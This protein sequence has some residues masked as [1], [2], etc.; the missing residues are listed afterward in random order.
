MAGNRDAF[1][2]RTATA[3]SRSVKTLAWCESELMRS[4]FTFS[5][6]SIRFRSCS[7]GESRMITSFISLSIILCL[8]PSG[9]FAGMP[10]LAV[11][12]IS[13]A[14][15]ASSRPEPSSAFFPFSRAFCF[16]FS[17]CFSASY[18][19]HSS[20]V[21]CGSCGMFFLV[22][23]RSFSFIHHSRRLA[24]LDAV[25]S[26]KVIAGCPASSR[27]SFSLFHASF[28]RASLRA[29]FSSSV[30]GTASSATPSSSPSS[31]GA[32]RP[33][34]VSMSCL[35]F[36]AAFSSA[37]AACC[38][39][40]FSARISSG[41]FSAMPIAPIAATFSA[42][43]ALAT[44]AAAASFSAASLTRRASSFRLAVASSAASAP[45]T[46]ASDVRI[47]SSL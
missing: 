15:M 10:V 3:L 47:A 6:S 24:S 13:P 35:A 38:A 29:S 21:S 40:N 8:M 17:F 2:S 32:S 4:F 37:L 30:R 19:S 1:P 28:C 33:A 20:N 42:T 31:A 26:S 34:A 39:A 23:R 22:A 46:W 43:A 11:A 14:T 36:F 16:F 27:V 18:T 12:H 45:L 7:S 41:G 25:N 5:A 9:R 44:A